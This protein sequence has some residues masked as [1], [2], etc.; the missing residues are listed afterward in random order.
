[1]RN[2]FDFVA[3]WIKKTQIWTPSGKAP[4]L[5]NDGREKLAEFPPLKQIRQ[6]DKAA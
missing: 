6:A 1:M 5:S 3:K 4:L 2:I